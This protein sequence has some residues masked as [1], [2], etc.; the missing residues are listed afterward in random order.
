M[1][2]SPL[3]ELEGCVLA[4]IW[5]G[6][7][8][9]PYAIRRE[10]LDS[11]SPQWSGSAGS[12]YPLVERLERRTL[13]R[14]TAHSTGRRAGKLYSLT[15]AGSRSLAMWLEA[16]VDDWV[17]G[18]PPDPLRTRAHFLGALSA[19]KREAFLASARDAVERQLKTVE[20]DYRRKRKGGYEYWATRGALL[21]MRA[22]RTWLIEL[23]D[24][25]SAGEV[26]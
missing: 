12:I 24:A 8:L 2:R 13:V 26:E 9:T 19:R 18:V 25:V 5:S 1:A 22:R 11:K 16:P 4:L 7:P 20:E 3:S 17:A 21:S 6:G 10:F 14:S 15:P 23:A